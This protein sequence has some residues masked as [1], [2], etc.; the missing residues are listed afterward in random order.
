[1][2]KTEIETSRPSAVDRSA[3]GLS[4]ESVEQAALELFA[5]LGFHA[6]SMRTIA[7]RVGVRPASLY[8]WFP[9]KQSLLQAIMRRFLAGLLHEVRGAVEGRG[10]A[11]ER[12][13]VA[14]WT[15]VVFH[16]R[17]RLAAFVT[18]TEVRAL[19]GPEG[20]NIMAMRDEYERLFRE[21]VET[22]LASGE[23]KARDARVAAYV[24]LLGCTGVAV[25]YRPEGELALEEIAAIHAEL[26]L[27]S[28]GIDLQNEGIDALVGDQAG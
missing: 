8:H 23:F 5:E 10:S 22:G 28:L 3:V 15:H 26:A 14:A 7:R 4:E 27:N 16:G 1:M 18:D 25:W 13:A 19:D 24:I 2:T 11:T 6:T 21:I 12:L 9:S 17:N 20:T